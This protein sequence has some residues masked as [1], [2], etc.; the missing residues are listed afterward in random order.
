MHIHAKVHLDSTT[1]L[2]TQLFFDDDV[3]TSVYRAAAYS[4]RGERDQFN[5]SDGIFDASLVLTTKRDG[6]GYLAA[7]SFD[8]RSA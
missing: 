1:V 3:S 7:M 6:D 2:T 5:D 8:V 4:E